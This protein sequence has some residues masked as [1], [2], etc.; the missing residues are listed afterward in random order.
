MFIGVRG[1]ST[2][3]QLWTF[4]AHKR[5]VER[6]CCDVC[7]GALSKPEKYVVYEREIT[8]G[9][10]SFTGLTE[11]DVGGLIKPTQT[12]YDVVERAY[13][14]AQT[15]MLLQRGVMARIEPHV[16]ASHE[17][18][19]LKDRL[20]K[21]SSLLFML[22]LFVRLQLHV[23]CKE[24]G[25]RSTGRAGAKAPMCRKLF[26]LNRWPTTTAQS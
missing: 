26:K 24:V 17:V 14:V 15:I 6:H 5:R 10:K 2:A 16:V 4:C 13:R 8:C 19:Y 1:A 20:C 23:M 9:L 11:V 3:R 25:S 22:R 12:F 7:Q 21:N 18:T